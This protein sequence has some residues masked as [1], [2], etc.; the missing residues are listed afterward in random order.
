MKV[1][2]AL[3]GG[4]VRGLAHVPILQVLDDLQMRP[5]VISGSSIGAIVGA[6][7]A[8][9]CSQRDQGRYRKTPHSQE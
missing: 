7:Y 3:G 8:S 2:I 6:L 9:A 1:G 5:A 4:G